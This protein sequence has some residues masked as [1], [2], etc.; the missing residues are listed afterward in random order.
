MDIL[1]QYQVKG[2]FFVLGTSLTNNN[3]AQAVLQRMKDDG[4]TT[5]TTYMVITDLQ[6]LLLN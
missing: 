1:D 2:T 3:Q 6:T 4:L 5:T